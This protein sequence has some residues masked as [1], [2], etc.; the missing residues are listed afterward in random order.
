MMRK[1]ILSAALVLCMLITLLPA[2]SVPA[3][4]GAE[5]YNVAE[6]TP[7]IRG[8][9][10]SNI[11]FGT[12]PQSSD[13]EGGYSDEPIKWRVLDKN[14]DYYYSRVSVPDEASFA[15]EIYY[16]FDT[17]SQT[18]S[19]A[20]TYSAGE[21]YYEK[22]SS[23]LLL[24]DQNLDAKPYDT[25][26]TSITWETSTIRSWLNGYSSADVNGANAVNP[27]DGSFIDS[28]FT[29]SERGVI[30]E[31][32]LSDVVKDKIVLLS[33]DEVNNSEYGFFSQADKVSSNTPYTENVLYGNTATSWW[34]RSCYSDTQIDYVHSDGHL[35]NCNPSYA[36]VS[37]RPAFRLDHD[38]VLFST[39]A[40]F[41][42]AVPFAKTASYGGS[43]WKLTL[44]DGNTGFEASV[45]DPSAAVGGSVTVNVA[46]LGGGT[47]YTQLSAM[48]IRS[49]DVICYG[50]VGEAETG[51][52]TFD[53]PYGLRTGSYTL[54]LFAEDAGGPYATSFASNTVNIPL[55]LTT[56]V[57]SLGTRVKL[58]DDS[59]WFV[60]LDE[61]TAA[62]R[63]TLVMD[64]F[65]DG[66]YSRP[67]V[68]AAISTY[69]ET[70]RTTFNDASLEAR[71]PIENEMI[72]LRDSGKSFSDTNTYYWLPNSEASEA[73][74][75]YQ[76]E[77]GGGS[78]TRIRPELV[79]G[80][81]YAIRPVV[82]VLKSALLI[83]E[84]FITQ[85]PEDAD[86]L[87]LAG[88]DAEFSVETTGIN[89]A[90]QWQ[91]KNGE[92]WTNI[93]GANGPTFTVE[94]DNDNYALGNSFRCRLDSDWGEPVYSGEAQLVAL[95]WQQ[96]GQQY[97]HTGT[98]YTVSEDG[99]TVTIHTEAGLG[100]L[101]AQVN[102]GNDFGGVTVVLDRDLDLSGRTFIPIGTYDFWDQYPFRGHFDGGM[103]TVRGLT[104]RG[105]S[106]NGLFGWAEY[107]ILEN[108]II[109]DGSVSVAEGNNYGDFYVGALC[110]YG[111][112]TTIR[113]V[114]IGPVAVS[115]RDNEETYWLGGIVGFLSGDIADTRVFNSYSMAV[116]TGFAEDYSN[117]NAGGIVGKVEGGSVANCYFSGTI[118]DVSSY[119]GGIA[120][121]VSGCEVASCIRS[122]DD[123]IPY[124]YYKYND[125]YGDIEENTGCAAVTEEQLKSS[126][127]VT[128]LN[129]WVAAENTATDSSIYELWG[130][131]ST[132]NGGYPV[133]NTAIPVDS[134]GGSSDS[135][136][137]S[138]PPARTITVTETSSGLFSGT[139]G[140]VRAE[141][142]VTSAFSNSVEVK[143][144]DTTESA[145][146]FGLGAGNN[147]YPFDISLYIKGTNIKTEPMDGYAVTISLPIPDFLLDVKEHL[148]IAHKA[149]DGT[150]T[151]L[152]SQLKQINGIWYLVFEAT[153]FSPYALVVNS[154]GTYDETAGLPY[155]MGAKGNRVFIG[156]AANGKY[157]AP[158]GATI[159]VIRNDKSFTDVAGHWA[160]SYIAFTAEREL[161]LGTGA[162]AFS[163]NSGMTRAMFATVIGRL[164][165]R[166]YGEIET[167]STHVF[168]DCDYGDY[169]GKYVV[170]AA[171]NGILDGYG[172]GEF[173]PD[174]PVTREQMAA[175]LYRFAD[176]LGVLPDD[177]DTA[178]SYPD[179][180]TISSY[181][182]S[183][184]LYCQSTGII[185]GRDGGSFVPQGTA[186]RAEVAVILERFIE[187]ILG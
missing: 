168:T 185:T 138:P 33:K 101:A 103:H 68:D 145:S 61:G 60:L 120:G 181:A 11:Y 80:T 172:N 151:T 19:E 5:S 65:L 174:D 121:Y 106:C 4:A 28:A 183:A 37:D 89:L 35:T 126:G 18:F 133:F 86:L 50:K 42:N 9:Q 49:G 69:Q 171:E 71:L 128:A 74:G 45:A 144:K 51:E 186:T 117:S 3:L 8:G 66:A 17:A 114:G 162:N 52:A 142:N 167:M 111:M 14:N 140:T 113:N 141:A 132:I 116:L 134:S 139:Q 57:F 94:A 47:G 100:W 123:D 95:D 137:D 32:A 64:G 155:Y 178:L 21:T 15:E 102:G 24:A 109:T 27:C 92:D 160:A 165:E 88:A 110:G 98:D 13:G 87:T 73:Y 77:N 59:I 177:M 70:A 76:Y 26:N 46:S 157:I 166:S 91:V 187:N 170:W 23:V 169:Y 85:Q 38:S 40:D 62:T 99:N 56:P 147:V 184:A 136:D 148:S 93:A 164:Y 104:A 16:T 108:L 105:N 158:E 12:Y 81:A 82:T 125:S 22:L 72:P 84:P 146:N 41:N 135:S 129:A 90:Y 7:L 152:A 10:A 1:R 31:A 97:A 78:Q 118:A 67:D 124:A 6:E 75:Y 30:V 107:A 182:E 43:D 163:P 159:S 63:F 115:S 79:G 36:F 54:R 96:Y 58:V 154:I 48:L 122:A 29:V 127:T 55:T 156:F 25:N 2:V 39:A 83:F 176:F 180:G 112:E 175:I 161:F 150:V 173:G 153:E 53:I 119:A 130:I 44:K 143:V 131:N 179:A 20:S 149:D 34:L